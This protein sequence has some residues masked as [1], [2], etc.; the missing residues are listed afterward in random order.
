MK[1]N[2][3]KYFF[4]AIFFANLYGCERTDRIENPSVS[5]L[6]VTEITRQTATG[7]GIITDDGGGNIL[8]RGLV[9][10]TSENP[11]IGDNDGITSE[12]PGS[13]QFESNLT[14]LSPGTTYFVSA[15]AENESGISYG[16]PVSFA[17]LQLTDGAKGKM[18]DIDGNIYMTVQIGDKEWMAENLSVY[19]YNNGDP[20]LKGLDNDQWRNT[21]SGALSVYPYELID[22]LNSESE[23]VQKYG[24]LYNWYAVGTGK[25]CPAGWEVPSDDDWKSLEGYTDSQFNQGHQEWDRNGWRGF[26]AG[27]RLRA[28]YDFGFSLKDDTWIPVRGSDDFGFSALPGGFRN[29]V[30]PH[31]EAGSYG[32]WW[33]RTEEGEELAL[34]RSMGVVSFIRRVSPGKNNGFSV[35]CIRKMPGSG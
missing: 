13:G 31:H 4:A 12:G 10:S 33:S 23:V 21:T 15:Y 27:Q 34:M 28:D 14:G 30:G 1:I 18:T 7:G 3:L 19:Q 6:E 26:D 8:S 22:G 25:L 35:R 32:Y 5:T 17:T 16:E 29:F 20:I 11:V 9:W 2:I 24:V